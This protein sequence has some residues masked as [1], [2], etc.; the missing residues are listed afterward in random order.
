MNKQLTKGENN[1]RYEQKAELQD[2]NKARIYEARMYEEKKKEI[3][4]DKIYSKALVYACYSGGPKTVNSYLIEK[5][6]NDLI[7]LS[8][9]YSFD[10]KN[11]FK[12]KRINNE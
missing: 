11:Y 6:F 7:N 4:T 3:N 1:M 10:Y 5:M 12:Q 2:S 9:E 8:D